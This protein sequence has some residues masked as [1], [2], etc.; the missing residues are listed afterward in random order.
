MMKFFR[1]CLLVFALLSLPAGAQ[2]ASQPQISKTSELSLT[3]SEK[4]WLNAHPVIRVGM[5]PDYAPYEWIDKD[6]QYVGLAVDYL[7]RIESV[8]GVRFEI[9]KGKTWAE[10]IEMTKR[11]E[12]D[13]LSSIVKTPERAQYFTYSEPYRNLQTAIIDRGQGDFIGS[14]AQLAGQRVAVEKGYFTQELLAKDHPDI[15]LVIASNTQ[16]AL[17]LLMDGKADA[18]VGDLGAINYAIKKAGRPNLRFSGQTDYQSQHRFAVAKAN[19]TLAL[20]LNKAMATIPQNE[21]DAIFNR[22]MGLRLVQGVP[23]NTLFKYGAGLT[24]LF[25]CFG[26]WVYRLRREIND[27]RAGEDRIHTIL[28]TSLDAVISMDAQ[29]RITD[30]NGR[31]EA[32]FDWSKSEVLGLMLDETIIPQRH[33]AAHRHGL[34]RFQKT[35]ESQVLNRRVEMSALRRN[36]DEFPI[37]LSISALKKGGTIEFN[38]FIADTSERQ[39]RADKLQEL[40]NQLQ[41]SE[42]LYRLLTEDALDVIW[43]TDCALLITYISPAD[44]RVRGYRAADLIGHH[45]FEMF[46]PE[47]VATVKQIMLQRQVAEQDGSQAGVMTFEVQHRCKDGRL[48]WGEVFSKPERD[49]SGAITGYHGITR[50]I[51]ERKQ[52]QDQVRQ[53]AFYDPLTQLPNRRLLHDR[54]SQAMTTSKRTGCHGALM[55]LDLDNFK[56][57]NDAHGHLV[58]DLLLIEV[59]R[60]LTTCVREMDT[61]ARFG[62]DEFVVMLS[63]LAHDKAASVSQAGFIAEDIRLSLSAPYRLE[64]R[65]DASPDATSSHT[66]EHRCTASI[67]VLVFLGAEM[68]QSD[69]LKRADASMY[70]AKDAGRNLVRMNSSSD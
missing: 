24:L 30:W 16:E 63:E 54:L 68:S 11:G 42:T 55:I 37:D 61:V 59:A 20:L 4:A 36:G 39:Q 18:Y 10:S 45:V 21:A 46:T 48:L 62:G 13:L 15:Q 3:A 57:L 52:M 29:G 28:E 2:T 53:L 60:R 40:S 64:V 25:L 41:E 58:G 5:D 65:D 47:G 50:E 69:V 38:A 44:E 34:A 9:S 23:T 27:R 19:T 8:L 12:L 67:G 1:F 14:L 17:S 49:A 26:Y 31:A 22:W 43:R 56:P 6:G 7:R 35:R 51:T 32:M 33:R 70:Q 66:V